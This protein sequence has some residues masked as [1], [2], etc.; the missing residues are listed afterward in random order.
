VLELLKLITDFFVLRDSAQKGMVSW[1]VVLFG[2]GFAIFLFATGVPAANYYDK[3]P[4]A[5]TMF[6][7]VIG[8]DVLA[9]VL[10]MIFGTRWYLRGMARYRASLA[11]SEAKGQAVDAR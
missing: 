5:S 1:R 4:E 6:Y 9:F 8:I 3:H 7:V 11:A 10:F 2:F